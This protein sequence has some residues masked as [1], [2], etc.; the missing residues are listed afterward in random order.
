MIEFIDVCYR[1]PNGTVAL[2]DVSLKIGKGVMAIVGPNGSGK[3]TLA[4]HMNGILKPSSGKVLVDGVDTRNTPVSKLSQIVGYVFQNPERMFF[5][6]TV[7]REVVFGPSNLG[8]PKEEVQ[9]R[10]KRA[11]ASVGLEGYEERN[12]LSLSGGEQKRLAIASILAMEPEYIVMDEPMA[13][14]DWWGKLDVVKTLQ[15]VAREGKGVVILTHD[16]ELVMRLA[17]KVVLMD[18]GRVAFDGNVEDFLNLKLEKYGLRT[19]EIVRLSRWFG[20][21]PVRTVEE[22]INLIGDGED[23]RVPK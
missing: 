5:E 13:G 9:R 2:R 3:T 6:D 14:L 10:G 4:L 17:E 7:F 1:Y 23:E 18:V 20:V 19:P 21:S 8:L 16:M 15:E 11:L 12:P 22:L